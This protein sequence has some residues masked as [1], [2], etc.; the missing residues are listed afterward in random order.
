MIAKGKRK[1]PKHETSGCSA[2]DLDLGFEQA[3]TIMSSLS[4]ALRSHYRFIEYDG[5]PG[6][7][8][9]LLFTWV[10]DNGKRLACDARALEEKES[11]FPEDISWKTFNSRKRNSRYDII[12]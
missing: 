6:G 7:S 4:S 9:E 1:Y 3:V 11:L 12:R 5:R 2:R 8:H 10:P